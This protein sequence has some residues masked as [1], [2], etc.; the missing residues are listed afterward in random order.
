MKREDIKAMIDTIDE[1]DL[2]TVFRVIARFV[3]D[4]APLPGEIQAIE[5]AHEEIANGELYD[6]V[7]W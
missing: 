1:R 6:N 4:D 7:E 2:G 5:N 3:P